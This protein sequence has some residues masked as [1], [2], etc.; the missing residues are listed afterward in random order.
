MS[1]SSSLIR[2]LD[3][4]T[5]LAGCEDGITVGEIVGALGQPRANVVRIV[6]TLVEHGLVSR[7]PGRR[8]APTAAFYDLCCRDRYG[9]LRHKYRPVLERLSKELNELVLLGVQEGNAII[10]IDYIES[11]HRVRVAPS[12]VTRHDLRRTAIGKV[13]LARRADLLADIDDAALL[14]DLARVRRTGIGWN[15]EETTGGVI[16]MACPGFSNA[17][18]EPI[19]AVAWP[20]NRYCEAASTA[21]HKA[22][23]NA[24]QH[25]GGQRAG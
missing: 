14:A 18:T 2:A 15:R 22:I 25:F 11:D 6:N 1:L 8:L 21:A 7:G 17:P 10:H 4:L 19:I 24:L 16:V 3:V 20:T 13:A 5:L 23:L 9:H 12:P